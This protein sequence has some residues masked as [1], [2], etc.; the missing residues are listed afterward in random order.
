MQREILAMPAVVVVLGAMLGVG[1]WCLSQRHGA[2]P[3]TR[4]VL[5]AAT[6]TATPSPRLVRVI[7]QVAADSAA[8]RA[9][10]LMLLSQTTAAAP[11]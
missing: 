7:A 3:A 2:T 9:H 4:P 8:Q 5:A 1:G 10:T 11:H 6:P